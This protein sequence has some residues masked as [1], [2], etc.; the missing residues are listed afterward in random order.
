[1]L[2]HC[3]EKW[4]PA[5]APPDINRVSVHVWFARIDPPDADVLRMSEIL[6]PEERKRAE[7]FR[8]ERDRGRFVVARAVLRKILGACLGVEPQRLSFRSGRNGK[9]ELAGTFEASKVRFNVSHSNGGALYAVARDREVGTDLEF[10]R[11]LDG[12]M[13]MAERSFSPAENAA[14]RSMRAP[15]RLRG[16]FDCWTRKEAFLKATG[17]GLS[18]SLEGFDVSVVPGPG[19]RTLF[20]RGNPTDGSRWT[21]TS[22][23]PHPAYAAALVV[24][25]KGWNLRTWQW[26]VEP[27][28]GRMPCRNPGEGFPLSRPA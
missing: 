10:I 26:T 27:D 18:S 14:L 19:P 2:N 11:P 5:P 20:A 25:G 22:L 12:L 16:F 13:A 6:S 4:V 23:A 1:M 24:E 9:P 15:E 8:F 7:S 21:L 28:P 17:E 3:R